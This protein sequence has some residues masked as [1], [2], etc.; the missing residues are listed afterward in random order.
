MYQFHLFYAL[1]PSNGHE[2]ITRLSQCATENLDLRLNWVH[3]KTTSFPG[4]WQIRTIH[5]KIEEMFKCLLAPQ[6]NRNSL[7][8][9]RCKK[10]K[11]KKSR[12]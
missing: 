12:F 11:G 2:I 5:G 9:I 1:K 3:P 7:Y 4:A 8:C 10:K 6:M